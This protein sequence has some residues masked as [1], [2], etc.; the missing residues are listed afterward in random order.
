MLA[1]RA[2]DSGVQHALSL[3]VEFDSFAHIGIAEMSYPGHMGICR[4]KTRET[5]AGMRRMRVLKVYLL[6]Q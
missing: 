6:S 1:C 3:G 5:S 4:E 2:Q